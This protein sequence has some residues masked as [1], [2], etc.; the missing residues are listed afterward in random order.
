M[1]KLL[2]VIAIVGVLGLAAVAFAHGPRGYGRGSGMGPGMMG[3]QAG[4]G[5]YGCPGFGA[6]ATAE[7][8]TADQAKEIAQKYADQY[9]KGFTVERVLPF[10]GMHHTMYSVELKGPNDEVRTFHI[11]PWGN[12]MPFAGP[13]TRTQ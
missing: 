10:T 3:G 9:L 8:I 5:G 7:A 1:K 6:R 11:N 4:P 12:V 2:G 13:V